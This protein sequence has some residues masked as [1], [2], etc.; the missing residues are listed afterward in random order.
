M[1]V[2]CNS[3]S[4]FSIANV[5]ASNFVR[6]SYPVRQS[7]DYGMLTRWTDRRDAYSEGTAVVYSHCR[8]LS[9]VRQHHRRFTCLA[10]PQVARQHVAEWRGHPHTYCA[11]HPH[12][13]YWR[14]I[15][16]PRRDHSVF[17]CP[18]QVR[19]RFSVVSGDARS[20][21]CCFLYLDVCF[22]TTWQA[23]STCP[24]GVGRRTAGCSEV[25]RLVV[26]RLCHPPHLPCLGR[27]SANFIT[28]PGIL[29]GTSCMLS[30]RNRH[31]CQATAGN[32]PITMGEKV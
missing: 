4:P 29:F 31:G 15:H 2:I 12:G 30:Q 13:T 20:G 10:I 26:C 18:T 24:T 22:D 9:V 7:L 8:D 14:W 17:P 1:N 27:I 21:S 5:A 23:D 3:P 11:P 32:H 6:Y 25:P 28:H 16:G 19:T